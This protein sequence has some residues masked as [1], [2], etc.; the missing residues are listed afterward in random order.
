LFGEE[1]AS[2]KHGVVSGVS[3]PAVKFEV[4]ATLGELYRAVSPQDQQEAK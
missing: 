3:V 2:M 4:G 1:T